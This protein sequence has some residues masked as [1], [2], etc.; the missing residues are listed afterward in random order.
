MRTIY[1]A[2]GSTRR[3]KL[4]AVWEALTVVGPAMDADAKFEVVGVEAPSGVTHTPL[5]RAELMAGSRQRAEYLAAL[6]RREGH[7]WQYF[8][9]L[10]GGFDVL[11]EDN[12]RLVFLQNWAYVLDAAGRSAYGHGAGILVP[13]PVAR[14]VLDDGIELATAIDAF[15][16]QRGIRDRQGAW[17]VFSRDLITRQDSFRTA[18]ISAFA[19]FFN[20]PAYRN[21]T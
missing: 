20:A 9:G 8:V 17:G 13:E 14:M 18:V 21:D 11:H 15:A 7:P 5:S 16:G 12:R 10:E 3:P 4:N 2:V 6:A 1:V 19:P